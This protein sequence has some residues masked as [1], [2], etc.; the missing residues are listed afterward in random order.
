MPREVAAEFIPL[1]QL[2]PWE[3]NPRNNR[4][5]IEQVAQSIKRFGFASPIIARKANSEIIAGHTRYEAAKKLGLK[6]VP[7]RFLDLD[8]TDAHLLALADNKLGEIAEWDEA[9][10]AGVL[11]DLRNQTSDAGFTESEVEALIEKFDVAFD[12][13]PAPPSLG[14]AKTVTCP[15]CSHEFTPAKT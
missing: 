2:K 11:K 5:A 13:I 15:N 1:E 9:I 6:T 7:V 3:N 4:K 12:P 10:L 14:N 8:P